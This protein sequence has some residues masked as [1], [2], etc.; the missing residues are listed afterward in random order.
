MTSS[1][2]DADI[3]LT[4]VS[5]R[6][7]LLG[8]ILAIGP[9]MLSKCKRVGYAYEASSMVV[10]DLYSIHSD[11]LQHLQGRST[12]GQGRPNAKTRFL[13]KLERMHNYRLHLWVF[14]GLRLNHRTS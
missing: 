4:L 13:W 9:L 6:Y 2:D 14:K 3:V 8:L 1:L 5:S 10:G 7:L 11:P 12:C